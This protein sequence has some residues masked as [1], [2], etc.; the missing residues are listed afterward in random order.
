[1]S[2]KQ[3]A[4]IAFIVWAL[5]VVFELMGL[6]SALHGPAGSGVLLWRQFAFLLR[7]G[8]TAAFFFHLSNRSAA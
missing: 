6:P 3:I 5:T 8:V 4:R 2:L 1:M 7:D